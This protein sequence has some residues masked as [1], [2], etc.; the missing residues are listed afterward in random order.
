MKGKAMKETQ[1]ILDRIRANQLVSQGESNIKYSN[2]NYERRKKKEEVTI[3]AGLAGSRQINSVPAPAAS[4]GTSLV[5]S[6][7]SVSPDGDIASLVPLRGGDTSLPEVSKD[8]GQEGSGPDIHYAKLTTRRPIKNTRRRKINFDFNVKNSVKMNKLTFATTY[9]HSE[10]IADIKKQYQAGKLTDADWTWYQQVSE[11][12]HKIKQQYPQATIGK[13]CL[14]GNR[15]GGQ[16]KAVKRTACIYTGLEAQVYIGTWSTTFDLE[17]IH[18]GPASVH[19][20]SMGEYRNDS[21]D[22]VD[23]TWE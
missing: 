22:Y 9:K 19:H 14:R 13:G 6:F 10:W 7:S 1:E 23:L 2:N 5:T 12:Y 11:D 18:S 17:P 4:S 8:P 21:S 3:S 20:D 16:L 15:R